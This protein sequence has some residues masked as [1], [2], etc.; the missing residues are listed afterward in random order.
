MGTFTM[1]LL[2]GATGATGPEIAVRDGQRLLQLDGQTLLDLNTPWLATG[3]WKAVRNF[4]ATDGRQPQTVDEGDFGRW[5]ETVTRGERGLTLRYEFQ[6]AADPAAVNLQWYWRLPPALFD[7]AQVEGQGAHPFALRPLPGTAI[8]GLKE[9]DFV[10]PAADLSVT[11]AASDGE[12]QLRDVRE[13]AWAKCYRLEYNRPVAL[14]G[15]RDG[16]FEVTLKGR[17]V[18][19]AVTALTHGKPFTTHGLAFELGPL[20]ADINRKLAAVVLLQTAGVAAPRGAEAGRIVVTYA[21]GATGTITLCYGQA[22]TA[23]LDDPRE[24]PQAALAQLPDGQPAWLATWRNPTPDNPVRSL[25]ATS[26]AAGWK[27]LAAAGIA[28]ETPPRR[29]GA[30][31]AAAAPAA[32]PET[33]SVSLNGAWRFQAAGGAERE[34]P[35]PAMWD[36]LGGLRQVHEA[37]YRRTFDVPAAMRGQ[38]LVLRFDAIGDAGEVWVNGCFAGQAANP[39][40]PVEF[41]ITGLVGAPSADNRLEVR[42][43]DDTHFTAPQYGRGG[44]DEKTWLPRGIGGD[45]RKGLIQDVNLVGRPTVAIADAR[46]QTSWRQRRLTVVYELRNSGKATVEAR[47]SATVRPAAGGDAVL[48]LPAQHVSLPGYV[49]TTVTLTAPIG[50]GITWWRPD[51]PALY[52]VGSLLDQDPGQRLDRAE[53]RFGFRETWFEGSHF[54]LDG[55]RCNLRGE[56]PCYAEKVDLFATRAAAE[57]MV[58]RYQQVNFNVLRFHALPAPPHVLDVCD[59]LGMMVIDESAIYASWGMLLPEHEQFLDNCRRHLAAF[60]RRDRN[61]PSVVLWSAE[62]EALNVNA[63]T[64][65]ML[66]EFRRV[67]DQHDGTRPVTFDGDGTAYGVG[68]ASNKHYVRTI[69]DLKDR[70][71]HSSGY[72]RDLRSDI[73]WACDYHQ[74]IP[75]G[76]GEFLFPYE[77]G[78]RAKERE[79][80]YMMGL[81]TRGHRLADWYDIRPYNPSYCGFLTAAGVK[82]G[83]EAGYDIV[84]KSFAPVAVFDRDYDA[85]GPFPAPPRLALGQPATRT[86]IVYNDTFADEAV[87]LT[88]Q[89]TSDGQRL[90]GETRRLT[91]PLGGHALLPITFTPARRGTLTLGLASAKGGRQT[92]SDTR[93]F[94]VE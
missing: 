25:S 46:V 10:L 6:L 40:L 27:L 45:S 91:V 42:V 20:S 65:A 49:T 89:A 2:L 69:D 18:G 7:A 86:L 16:W 87:D 64:P 88:W 41:D 34:I 3:D 72:A 70:G 53:T 73:Y 15:K 47:L 90:A 17:A 36:R 85:L 66:A 62:N 14:G 59:E 56:S 57:A 43:Q 67:I 81:Q 26:V 22:V 37:T 51:Q 54:Y 60:V 48:T 9:A 23:P 28:G 21:D 12:W 80:C 24:L 58:R 11:L 78:L 13:A 29:L 30:L 61:H 38:R 1:L 35:V 5:T 71:G 74:E 31:L 55:I 84:V 33:I 92:F 82:P 79:V 8:D 77:P 83:F 39:T 75:L 44:H 50:E 32:C 76:C 63:L 68:V 94:V 19:D 52:T 4:P 93:D